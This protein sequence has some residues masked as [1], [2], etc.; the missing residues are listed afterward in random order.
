MDKMVNTWWCWHIY[1]AEVVG[2]ILD[3]V[4]EEKE[5][6][7]AS[8]GCPRVKKCNQTYIQRAWHCPFQCAPDTLGRCTATPYNV[9]FSAAPHFRILGITLSSEL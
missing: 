7:R 9:P 2:V 1:K 6:K 8:L 5:K 3:E 4:G